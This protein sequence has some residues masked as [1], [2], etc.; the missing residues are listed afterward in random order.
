MKIALIEPRQGQKN[1]YSKIPMPL[2]GLIYLGTILK[3]RG[4]QVEIYNEDI[5]VPDYSKIDADLIGISILTVTA[6]RGYE[7][8]KMFPKEKVIIGGIHASLLP[9]EAIQYARQ[10]VIGEAE[11]VIVDVVEGRITDPIVK[12]SPVEHLDALPFPDFSLIR[13]YN[14]NAMITP[15]STSRG[16]PYDCSFCTV[17]K[18]FGRKYRFRS[19]ENV[20]AEIEPKKTRRFFFCDDNFTA[21]PKRTDLLLNLLKKHKIKN[22][23]CQVRCDVAKDEELLKKM[24]RAGCDVVCVGFE[25]INPLSLEA[26]NKKQSVNEIINAIKAFHRRNIKIHGMFVFGSDYDNQK[27]VWETLR[28]AIKHGID[29]IQMMILTPFP[30]TQVHEQLQKEN[31][32]FSRDWSLYD[33]QNIVFEP[34]LLSAQELQMTVVNAYSKF[35]SISRT[36]LMFATFRFRNAMFNIMGWTIFRDWKKLHIMH[37]KHTS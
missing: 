33:G 34:L 24:S 16:C 19:A 28:F 20:M 29:T 9:E 32:I 35:Y 6:K 26:F 10:V 7:I 27:T 12:G 2:L 5:Y 25:S 1:V 13:G 17:T 23:A 31:R 4:H 30:G 14:T 11:N 36:L 18:L 22:W 15:I 37:Q 21:N 8:A 3:D